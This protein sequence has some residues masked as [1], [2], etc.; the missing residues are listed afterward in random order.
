MVWSKVV[1]GNNC[2]SS[3]SKRM[4]IKLPSILMVV[5]W[6][7]LVVLV[8]VACLGT[9]MVVGFKDSMGVWVMLI[10]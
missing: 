5:V 10:S 7:I 3:T 6:L 2:G 1:G 8:L 4:E 9:L